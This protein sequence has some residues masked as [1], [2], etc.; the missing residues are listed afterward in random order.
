VTGKRIFLK[1]R[2]YHPAQSRESSPEIRHSGRDPNPCPCRQPDHP[3][4]HSSTVR[5]VTISTDPA[6][7]SVPLGSLISIVPDNNL[8]SSPFTVSAS[9]SAATFTGRNCEVMLRPSRPSRYN[10]RQ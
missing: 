1:R 4:R 7:R 3:A 8:E 2:L 6:I 5:S 10:F 9:R